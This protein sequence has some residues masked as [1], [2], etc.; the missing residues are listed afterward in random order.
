MRVGVKGQDVQ[1]ER[2]T[3][4]ERE[5]CREHKLLQGAFNVKYADRHGCRGSSKVRCTRL[6]FVCFSQSTCL[7]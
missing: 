4:K 6:Y 3:D 7:G 5:G 1:I 2:K